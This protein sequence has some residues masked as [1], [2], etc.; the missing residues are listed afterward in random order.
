MGEFEQ[1]RSN[2]NV[3]TGV[4]CPRPCRPFRGCVAKVVIFQKKPHNG[5]KNLFA[6]VIAKIIIA[7]QKP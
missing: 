3:K 7:A 2:K 6:G 1:Q 5:L 4:K